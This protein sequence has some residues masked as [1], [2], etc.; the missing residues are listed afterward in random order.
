MNLPLVYNEQASFQD[1][2]SLDVYNEIGD[3]N[4]VASER[5]ADLSWELQR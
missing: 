1:C 2:H 3:T 4:H 5:R